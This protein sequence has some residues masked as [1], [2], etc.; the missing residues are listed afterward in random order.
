MTKP[1]LSN[2]WVHARPEQICRVGM[3]QFV[4]GDL[5]TELLTHLDH[6]LT[7]IGNRQTLGF[8]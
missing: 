4:K 3:P 2:F 5:D 6:S 8:R 1:L 7:Q